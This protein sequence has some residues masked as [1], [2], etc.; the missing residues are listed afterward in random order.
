MDP[1]DFLSLHP[2]MCSNVGG[3]FA[4]R[5]RCRTSLTLSSA[6]RNRSS[7]TQ[8]FKNLATKPN[9]FV[10]ALVL[11]V[12]IQQQRVVRRARHAFGVPGYECRVSSFG[13]VAPVRLF[14]CGGV[15]AVLRG[16]TSVF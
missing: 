5:N 3:A 14:R 11:I 13:T 16:S 10:C 15:L 12:A 2:D 6:Y 1:I 7:N 9:I 4:V 8:L